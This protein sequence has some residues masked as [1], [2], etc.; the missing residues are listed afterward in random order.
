MT[1]SICA[2][3]LYLVQFYSPAGNALTGAQVQDRFWKKS[4]FPDTVPAVCG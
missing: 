4:V 2:L 1:S 3:P